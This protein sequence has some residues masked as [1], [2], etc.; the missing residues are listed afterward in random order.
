VG[1]TAGGRALGDRSVDALAVDRNG[2]IGIR[3]LVGAIRDNQS[4]VNRA[5]GSRSL[6]HVD[7]VEIIALAVL[8]LSLGPDGVSAASLGFNGRLLQQ[9]LVTPVSEMFSDM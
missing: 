4:R 7:A 3:H 2:S 8:G 5:A 6:A 9:V 1:T